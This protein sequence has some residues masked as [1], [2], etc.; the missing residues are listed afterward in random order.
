MNTTS[1]PKGI[2]VRRLSAADQEE[3]CRHFQRLDVESRHARFG[4]TVS[5]QWVTDYAKNIFHED[6][7]L[8]GAFFEGELCGVAELQGVS[9]DW[10]T[11]AELAFS[12]EPGRQNLGIGDALFDRII[13][14]A[15]NRGF[16]SIQLMC[17]KENSRMKH[18]AVKH[19]ADLTYGPEG[20]EATLHPYWPTP[21]SIAKEILGEADGWLAGAIRA[22]LHMV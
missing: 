17:L 2:S 11:S 7:I 9:L 21:L 16:R 3:I 13:A 1:L 6:S 8:C 5:D 14:I 22:K 20:V 10:E 4:G 12:V 18:L 19:Q 15:Q